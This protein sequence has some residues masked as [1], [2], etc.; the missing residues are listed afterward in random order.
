MNL[1][2][3]LANLA[4]EDYTYASGCALMIQCAMGLSLIEM[5]LRISHKVGSVFDF[6]ELIS[7]CEQGIVKSVEYYERD[8]Q[9]LLVYKKTLNSSILYESSSDMLVLVEGFLN[10]L[11]HLANEVYLKT[12]PDYLVGINMI[13]QVREELVNNLLIKM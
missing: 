4:S 2:E 10:Q 1:K 11:D 6:K 5:S 13:K 9:S 12:K 7:V 8:H 3:L